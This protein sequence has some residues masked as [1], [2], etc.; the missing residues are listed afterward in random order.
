MAPERLSY[1]LLQAIWQFRAAAFIMLLTAALYPS[2][3]YAQY[4]KCIGEDGVHIYTN[5][6]CP[7]DAENQR[8]ALPESGAETKQ[9][10]GDD[11]SSGNNEVVHPNNGYE[12][13]GSVGL[14]I[15]TQGYRLSS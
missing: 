11:S 12:N 6:G 14:E 13:T 9:A 8:F 4:Y 2:L 10:P 5:T 7:I 1:R 3:L 15:Y